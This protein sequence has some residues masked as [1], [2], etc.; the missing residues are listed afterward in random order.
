MASVDIS[1]K[2]ETKINTQNKGVTIYA[3]A[4]MNDD[5][6]TVPSIFKANLLKRE[7]DGTM[8]N[9]INDTSGIEGELLLSYEGDTV[10]EIDKPT[11]DLIIEPYNDNA[12]NYSR[13][14]GGDLI[15]LIY[16]KP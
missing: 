11:G 4:D 12:D 16:T 7:T 1:V 14:D 3:F 5:L 8:I 2:T 15:D 13:E 10:G 9:S 6:T